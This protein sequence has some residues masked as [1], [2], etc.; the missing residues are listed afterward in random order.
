MQLRLLGGRGSKKGFIKFSQ[1]RVSNAANEI[2]R[3][4]KAGFFF[5][6]GFL[7][8][9][10]TI[11]RIAGEVEGYLFNSFLPLPLFLKILIP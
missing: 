2:L 7:S 1:M 3:P 8:E 5:Y 10:F 9:T 4:V 6:L 11:H